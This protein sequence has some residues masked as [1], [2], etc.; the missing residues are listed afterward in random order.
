LRIVR[1]NTDCVILKRTVTHEIK[2]EKSLK[3]VL[4]VFALAIFANAFQFS[5]PIEDAMAEL[6]HGARLWLNITHQ[7]SI[8]N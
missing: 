2:L 1:S 6:S 5:S 3:I 7:G 8:G 4:L